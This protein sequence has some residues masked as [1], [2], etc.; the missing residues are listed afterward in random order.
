M[1]LKTTQNRIKHPSS[2]EVEPKEQCTANVK[3]AE[4]ASA[5]FE[6]ILLPQYVMDKWEGSL[7]W[8]WSHH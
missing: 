1:G 8:I 6:P 5:A 2:Q 3:S 4:E 7:Q